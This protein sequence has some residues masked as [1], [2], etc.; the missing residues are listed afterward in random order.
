M[1]AKPRVAN[2]QHP[3]CRG[4][5]SGEA[6]T[7]RG[8]ALGEAGSLI[9]AHKNTLLCKT[10]P[11]SPVFAPKTHFWKK[12][13][14]IQTQFFAL[15]ALPMLPIHPNQTQFF[16]DST[17]FSGIIIMFISFFK[18]FYQDFNELFDALRLFLSQTSNI[19]RFTQKLWLFR[20]W[21]GAS[22]SKESLQPK[23]VLPGSQVFPPNLSRFLPI[24]YRA[25]LYG[26][27]QPRTRPQRNSQQYPDNQQQR[28]P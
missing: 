14:P 15:F 4:Q 12:T 3:A 21:T 25:T 2:H 1:T 11:I 28:P 19:S 7:C 10:N 16:K 13:N 6:G 8:V 26:I 23:P 20:L 27:K 17:A 24:S 9:P 18:Y 22:E 5:S